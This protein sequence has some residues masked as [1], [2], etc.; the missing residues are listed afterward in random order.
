[1][2]TQIENQEQSELTGDG[3]VLFELQS[4]ETDGLEELQDELVGIAES[5][6]V[7]DFKCD[8]CGLA[9]GHDTN[10]HRISDSFDISPE[11]AAEM[12]MN[13][14]CHCGYNESAHRGDVYGIDG[15]NPQAAARRAPIPEGTQAQIRNL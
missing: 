15:P 3:E 2:S 11:E 9:H 12:T 6:R 1:M 8:A 10:K 13:P 4:G 7:G 14:N 5:F